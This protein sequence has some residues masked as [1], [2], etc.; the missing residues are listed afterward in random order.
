[1]TLPKMPLTKIVARLCDKLASGWRR[2]ARAAPRILYDRVVDKNPDYQA[3]V[4]LAGGGR[5]GTTW[6]AEII[7][8]DNA[9]RF[10]FEPF[11]HLRVRECSAF[12]ECQY[13]RREDNDVRFLEP[14]KKIFS[15]RIRNGWTDVYN[16]RLTAEKRLIKEI[17]VNL[18]LGWIRAHFPQVPVVLLLRHPCAVAFSRC[19]TKW[20][21]DLDTTFLSQ[22]TLMTDYLEPFR[23]LLEQAND[24]FERH[25]I[26]WCIENYV[27]LRQLSTNDVLVITY[28]DCVVS[29][30]LELSRIFD[31]LHQP[32]NAQA[33][34]VVRK[35]SSQSR[36]N[37]RS[38]NA[39]PIVT[40]ESIVD[41]WTR[42]VHPTQAERAQEIISLFGLNEI[43]TLDPMP[44]TRAIE[45]Y[46]ERG[47]TVG[48]KQ[49]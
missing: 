1:M 4:L 12:G 16:R 47:A 22:R 42:H 2:V 32:F 45:R 31:F 7:N 20:V 49:T 29:P 3:S 28:E 21:A 18:M 14:A 39:S 5:G 33:L 9:Y 24:E 41:A 11:N 19:K 37:W 8:Y 43:Y 34:S 38:G 27:P 48:G 13:L 23:V 40:G 46:M 36:R 6:L 44:H 17:R 15:G 26:W 10:M 30:E 35:P 25:I